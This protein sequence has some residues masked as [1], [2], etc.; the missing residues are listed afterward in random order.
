[1]SDLHVPG[2]SPVHRARPGVKLAL[3]AVFCT[4][5]FILDDPLVTAM[6]G[7]LVALGY[8]AAG[9]RPR[10]AWTSLRPAL[11]P[12]VIVFLAQLVLADAGTAMFVTGRFAVLILAASLLT[13]TTRAVDLTDSLRVGLERLSPRIP[14]DR[15]ALA[16]SLCLRFIPLVR[17]VLEDIRRAQWSR[18]LERRPLALLVPLIV[19]TLRTA[20]EMAEAIEAR[21]VE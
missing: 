8:A 5:V 12:L 15:I 14:A 17:T 20:D 2:N 1:M 10:H 6:S 18:G 21:S 9:L 4:A 19:R 16:V 11:W 13:L 3:L 7:A